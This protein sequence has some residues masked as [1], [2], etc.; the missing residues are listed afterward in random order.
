MMT[1]SKSVPTSLTEQTISQDSSNATSSAQ[2]T[3]SQDSNLTRS[4]DS[5]ADPASCAE[6]SNKHLN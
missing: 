3:T 1:I 6:P 2:E 5:S 4:Q